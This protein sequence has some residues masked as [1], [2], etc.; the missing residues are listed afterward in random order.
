[1]TVREKNLLKVLVVVFALSI[2][3]FNFNQRIEEVMQKRLL[4][5]AEKLTALQHDRKDIIDQLE[6]TFADDVTTLV[7]LYSQV[8]KNYSVGNEFSL[9]ETLRDVAI[10]DRLDL[11]GLES[12]QNQIINQ[13]PELFVVEG[14]EIQVQG[15]KEQLSRF[16]SSILNLDTV[17]IEMLRYNTIQRRGGRLLVS[18]YT[19]HPVFSS[20]HEL[21]E[22]AVD[23][24]IIA[25]YLLSK[26]QSPLENTEIHDDSHTYPENTNLH[27]DLA[28]EF[29]VLYRSA[30]LVEEESEPSGLLEEPHLP[31]S[32]TIESVPVATW[33]TYL[34][35]VSQKDGT[36]LWYFKH[37]ERNITIVIGS[38]ITES[39]VGRWR[40]V[41]NHKKTLVFEDNQNKQWEVSIP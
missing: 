20:E 35:R 19:R 24:K 40:L 39:S 8:K 34:G 29:H 27:A 11:L 15:T 23:N 4:Q 2:T 17:S 41:S 25:D 26:F 22:K 10:R 38:S 18:V 13:G 36:T 6:G 1:M 12:I 32:D 30:E 33:L 37:T 14:W 21:V 31:E 9:G 28:K 3:V 16:S 7:N 5:H